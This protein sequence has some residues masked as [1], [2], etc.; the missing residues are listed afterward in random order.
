MNLYYKTKPNQTEYC[1]CLERVF[2]LR[3][4][5][6]EEG[7]VE[8]HGEEEGGVGQQGEPGGEPQQGGRGGEGGADK[9][10]LFLLHILFC[11]PVLIN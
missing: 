3:Y 9:A 7:E 10:V 5:G 4:V 2:A 6:G 11:S 8:E 1:I